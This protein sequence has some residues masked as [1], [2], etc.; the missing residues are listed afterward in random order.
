MYA[1]IAAEYL[2]AWCRAKWPTP[3]KHQ[4][5]SAQMASTV[6]NGGMMDV[7]DFKGHGTH[8][9]IPSDKLTVD[10]GEPKGAGVYGYWKM[11][12]NSYLLLTC[13]GRLAYWNGDEEEVAC[14]AN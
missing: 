11:A 9:Y 1:Q 13:N 10:L 14:W 12:D 3:L 7:F 2:H 8:K 6:A 4:S 5:D